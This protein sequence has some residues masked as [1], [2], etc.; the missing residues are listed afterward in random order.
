MAEYGNTVL[1]GIDAADIGPIDLD[2]LPL[3][4]DLKNALRAWAETYD[5]TLNQEY[6]P[7][8]GFASPEDEAAF[9]AEGRRLWKDLQAQLG[10]EFRVS[11]YSSR[12]ARL[13]E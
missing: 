7:D 13:L 11:Y 5:K 8:S 10:P 12:E 1:W 2:Q 4:V 9:E 6:P 3:T